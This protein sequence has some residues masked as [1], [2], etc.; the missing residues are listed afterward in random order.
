MAISESKFFI[1]ILL[2]ILI[3]INFFENELS[4]QENNQLFL[5]PD[6][7]ID[8]NENESDGTVKHDAAINTVHIASYIKNDERITDSVQRQWIYGRNNLPADHQSGEIDS[9]TNLRLLEDKD[10]SSASG[11]DVNRRNAPN[12]EEEINLDDTLNMEWNLPNTRDLKRLLDLSLFPETIGSAADDSIFNET[13][14]LNIANQNDATVSG[15]KTG[16][17]FMNSAFFSLL[18]VEKTEQEYNWARNYYYDSTPYNQIGS[19]RNVKIFT[20]DTHGNIKGITG[21]ILNLLP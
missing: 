19:A 15:F 3:T 4:A 16:R 8:T 18:A 10:A 14:L 21:R 13:S 7:S 17:P 9:G 1:I 11:Y 2:G 6:E 5:N 12:L 20:I